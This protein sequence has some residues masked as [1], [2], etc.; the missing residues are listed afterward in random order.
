M[1][2]ELYNNINRAL[3]LEHENAEHASRLLQEAM[4]RGEKNIEMLDR[5]ADRLMD[6]MI[7]LSGEGEDM[8]RTYL[9][10]IETFNPTE[11]KE[12]KND[13]EYDL[14]YKTHVL[15]AAAML[16]QK[17][18]EDFTATNG[19]P[20]FDVIMHEYIPKVY[21]ITKKTASFLFF[22]YFAH[23][24]SLVELMRMLKTIT[25]ETDYIL[26]HIEEYDDLMHYPRETYHPLREDEWQLIQ[27]IAEHNIDLYNAHPE[28]NKDLLQNVFGS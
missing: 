11:A 16:C 26:D 24:H 7:G 25:E 3:H 8:Y 2:D 9:D 21:D 6:S 17:E 22:A 28:L 5:I 27:T 4:N 15:Y 14:G 10:Y 20:A 23:H 13:L 18:V 1:D 19:K 12:R